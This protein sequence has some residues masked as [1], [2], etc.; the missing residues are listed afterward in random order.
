MQ[1]KSGQRCC[2]VYAQ[3]RPYADGAGQAM[4]ETPQKVQSSTELSNPTA[5]PEGA[6]PPSCCRA[7]LSSSV[8]KLNLSGLNSRSGTGATGAGPACESC[9]SG[10]AGHAP[11]TGPREARSSARGGAA[12]R[13]RG[14]IAN[15]RIRQR[16]PPLARQGKSAPRA[17]LGVA[18]CTRRQLRSLS[19]S[20][21]GRPGRELPRGLGRSPL[22]AAIADF[23]AF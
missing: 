20:R 5:G 9:P 4:I 19:T 18:P 14:A 2:S 11:G 13:S 17:T 16:S 12:R 8:E 1:L 3:K 15:A 21:A 23:P 22:T 6:G 10:D 7:E